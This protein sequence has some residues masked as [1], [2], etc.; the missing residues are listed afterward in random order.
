MVYAGTK[1]AVVGLSTAL[2]DE[3]APQGVE[4]SVVMPP[5]TNTELI[6][7]TKPAA[8]SKPVEPE[9]I[10]AAIVKVLNKS[11]THV[12][13]P[14]GLR[15]VLKITNDRRAMA[16][17]QPVTDGPA[18]SRR[19][20][21]HGG[22]TRTGAGRNGL[23]DY[24]GAAGEH[25]DGDGNA[26]AL[27]DLTLRR[28]VSACTELDAPACNTWVSG[29]RHDTPVQ[30]ITTRRHQAIERPPCPPTAASKR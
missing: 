19:G 30:A 1:F 2:A 15:F 21:R 24:E 23:G 8:A 27:V 20:R 6:S 26:K 7:G 14:G 22:H 28:R 10:A 9:D 11:K 5:F 3:F 18:C 25:T 12:S 16:V 13:V 17:A 4:V 29:R